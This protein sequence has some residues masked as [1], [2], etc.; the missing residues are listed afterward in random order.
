MTT[1]SRIQCPDCPDGQLWDKDGPTED[2]CPRCGGHA[3]I[4]T[5]EE[6]EKRSS[7][8]ETE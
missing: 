5:A 2:V 3:F 4:W 1:P 7:E 8:H 6:A